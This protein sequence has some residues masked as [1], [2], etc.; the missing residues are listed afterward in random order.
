LQHPFI[1]LALTQF[2][3]FDGGRAYIQTQKWGRL[4]TK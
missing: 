3:Q 2:H 1:G 4:T